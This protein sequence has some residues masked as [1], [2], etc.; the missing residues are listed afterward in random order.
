LGQRVIHDLNTSCTF[1]FQFRCRDITAMRICTRQ[2]SWYFTYDDVT[3]RV[4]KRYSFIK[5][6]LPL[7]LTIL[8]TQNQTG[9]WN[10]F[11]H[12]SE[13]SSED[14]HPRNES[15]QLIVRWWVVQH[16]FSCHASQDPSYWTASW[17]FIRKLPHGRDAAIGQRYWPFWVKIYSSRFGIVA[18]HCL[19]LQLANQS[20]ASILSVWR[21][22]GTHVA[23]FS[24]LET[25]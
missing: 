3:V 4:I 17:P 20:Q 10:D 24:A 7:I 12:M 14:G 8:C 21:N 15:R 22:L 9:T 11:R 6:Y 1:F 13:K 25:A 23:H 16:W 5:H 19:N 2:K 18:I